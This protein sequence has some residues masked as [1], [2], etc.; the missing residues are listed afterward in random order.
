MGFDI[1]QDCA[2]NNGKIY[3]CNKCNAQLCRHTIRAH[4]CSATAL[5]LRGQASP[6]K[7][8]ST[9]RISWES[10]KRKNKDFT[11]T[12]DEKFTFYVDFPWFPFTQLN[13]WIPVRRNHYKDERIRGFNLEEYFS[14]QDKDIDEDKYERKF[15]YKGWV[16]GKFISWQNKWKKQHEYWD[17]NKSQRPT[18]FKLEFPQLAFEDLKFLKENGIKV[19]FKDKA[20]NKLKSIQSEPPEKFLIEVTNKRGYITIKWSE[21]FNRWFSSLLKIFAQYMAVRAVDETE[22]AILPCLVQLEERIVKVN[23]WASFRANHFWNVINR[24]L[25]NTPNPIFVLNYKMYPAEIKPWKTE[26]KSTFTLRSYQTEAIEKWKNNLLF[27]TI[28]LPTG[29]GKTVVGIEALKIT[30]ERALILVPNLTL[31]DQWRDQIVDK[32]TFDKKKIGIFN[33]QKKNF[34][35]LPIVISTYQLL[36][37]YL[38]DYHSLMDENKD[39]SKDLRRNKEVVFDTIGFFTEKFGIIIADES[40]HIQAE[41]FRLIAMNLEIP[42]RLALSATIESS[43]HS[44]LVIATMGPIIY[45]LTYGTLAREGFIAPI[46]FR[47][48]Y[49]PL[50]A[51]EENYLKREAYKAGAKGKVSREAKNK[52]PVLKKLLQASF[53][54]QSLVFTS[55]INHAEVIHKYL[56]K[57][58]I[59]NTLLTGDSTKN[60]KQ[61]EILDKFRQGDI[62]TL[63]LVKKLNEGFDAPADTVI[64]VSGTRNK[65]EQIQRFGRATRPG[66]VAKLFEII[67]DPLSLEY[68]EEVAKARDISNI[69]EP[70]VQDMLLPK[71]L[72]K[73]IDNLLYE[74]K[75]Q[76]L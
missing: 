24:T 61:D 53:T 33:G 37:Q 7:K 64:I 18:R 20:E 71:D 28:Q 43:G 73:D 9:T 63:I 46:C 12:I 57:H 67:V 29:A 52:L 15:Y 21:P 25:K 5:G 35:G 1:C 22:A 41:T 31:V 48:I 50:K 27:G 30:N 8:G 65:R 14:N 10:F 59:K 39:S 66:K 69:I 4:K 16:N 36:S 34:K 23:Y 32:L 3:L 58:N 6:L 40:H 74:I 17:K 76:F 13:A 55:R 2:E 75:S 49:V 42:K 62:N 11:I 38:Q 26:T 56:K 51:D 19:V 44:S 68:E 45:D 72:K 60:Q 70:W 47:R 54:T